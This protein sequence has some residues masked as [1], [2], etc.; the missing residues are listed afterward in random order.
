[1]TTPLP[2]LP[3]GLNAQADALA[4]AICAEFQ[5][6]LRITAEDLRRQL[7][8]LP[9]QLN[10]AARAAAQYQ[11][12]ERKAQ[13]ALGRER[14]EARIKLRDGLKDVKLTEADMAAHVD[15]TPRVIKAEVVHQN[16]RYASALADAD[17]RALACKEK[18]LGY[19]VELILSGRQ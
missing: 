17:L 12:A 11:E 8:E 6:T 10:I 16:A 14:A 4:E 7:A 15:L 18:M 3:R 5:K 2:I 13:L 9:L 1:M 19:Y